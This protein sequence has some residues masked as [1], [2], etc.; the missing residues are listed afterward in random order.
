MLDEA[1]KA[2][3]EFLSRYPYCYGYWKKYADLEKRHGDMKKVTEVNRIDMYK[4]D[5]N[6]SV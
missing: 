5:W 2:Y 6:L 3:D 1:R 4:T